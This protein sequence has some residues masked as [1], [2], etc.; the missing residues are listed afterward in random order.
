M[1]RIQLE[2]GVLLKIGVEKKLILPGVVETHRLDERKKSGS[3]AKDKGRLRSAQPG[4]RGFVL[5]LL[6][7][8]GSSKLT[9]D[10]TFQG[11]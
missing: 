3:D 2:V 9:K 11:W 4:L 8:G 6:L 10:M 1:P 5:V 7:E